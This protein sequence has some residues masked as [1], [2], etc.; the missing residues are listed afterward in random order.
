[1]IPAEILRPVCKRCWLIL[2]LI[3]SQCFMESIHTTVMYSE[4]SIIQYFLHTP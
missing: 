2:C 4:Y 1:M 3:I